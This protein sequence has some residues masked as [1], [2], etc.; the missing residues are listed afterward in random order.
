MSCSDRYRNAPIGV[1]V[2]ER[3]ESLAEV[4]QKRTARGNSLSITRKS[5]TSGGVMRPYL[6]RYISKPLTDLQYGRPVDVIVRRAD[7]ERP[8]AAA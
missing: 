7:V 1:P 3:S 4:M 2:I 8:M 5:T 6:F